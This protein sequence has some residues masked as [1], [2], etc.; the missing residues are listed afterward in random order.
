MEV[1]DGGEEHQRLLSRPF[2]RRGDDAATLNL[3]S[4]WNI[5]SQHAEATDDPQLN[6]NW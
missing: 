5:P 3:L 1:G 2:Y 4:T 6:G